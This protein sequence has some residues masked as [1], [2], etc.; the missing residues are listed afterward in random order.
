MRIAIAALA[1]T[2]AT[3]VVTSD[4]VSMSERIEADGSRTLSHEIV[5]DSPPDRVWWALATADGWKSW[6]VPIAF[7]DFRLGGD[8]ETSYDP[9]ATQ[10]DPK[11][12]KNRI[13]AYVPG[14][15][16]AFQAVQAPPGFPHPEILPSLWS[17]AEIEP[18]GKGRTRLRLSGFGYARTAAHDRL[19]GFFK[20]GNATSLESLRESLEKGPVDW[21]KKLGQN[22]TRGEEK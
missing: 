12:I 3:P 4:A 6:A 20:T 8:I 7:M 17:V 22:V 18:A 5:L 9:T 2:I 19:Y 21:G 14:R 15:M 10:G 1:L 16:L 11:N 13:L